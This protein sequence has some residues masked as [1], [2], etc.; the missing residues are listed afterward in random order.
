M[1]LKGGSWR[2]HKQ[3]KAHSSRVCPA[4]SLSESCEAWVG[5]VAPL[6]FAGI[7]QPPPSVTIPVD[8]VQTS[9]GFDPDGPYYEV[10]GNIVQFS[11]S[12]M[13]PSMGETIRR[14]VGQLVEELEVWGSGLAV[15]ML[16][17]G[18]ME[19]EGNVKVS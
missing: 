1:I 15:G 8:C 9:V 12:L 2:S 18:Q 11:A 13:Y 5:D 7:P 14:E 17:Q 4:E 3:S 19:W 6:G 16:K 10:D